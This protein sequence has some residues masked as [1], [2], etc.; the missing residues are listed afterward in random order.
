ME[1]KFTGAELISICVLARDKYLCNGRGYEPTHQSSPV[2]FA[3]SS[4]TRKLFGG[5]PRPDVLSQLVIRH[6]GNYSLASDYIRN[7]PGYH[8][9]STQKVQSL[10]AGM[11]NSMIGMIERGEH[12]PK[13]TPRV[14]KVK[15]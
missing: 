5:C 14:K 6:I 3:L 10:R 7:Q 2:C 11:I 13:P 9:A 1:R 4:A 15:A 8:H 12:K